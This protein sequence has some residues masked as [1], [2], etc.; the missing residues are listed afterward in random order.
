M[1]WAR[2]AGPTAAADGRGRERVRRRHEHAA[3][4]TLLNQQSSQGA[5]PSHL[6][7]DPTG[8]NVLVA[9]Y[10]SGSVAVLPID[11]DGRLGPVVGACTR[12]QC[13]EQGPAGQAARTRHLPRLHRPVVFAADLGLDQVLVYDF[14]PAKGCCALRRDGPCAWLRA[15]PPGVPS[16]GRFLRH[17]RDG[18]DADR[19]RLRRRGGRSSGSCRPSRPCRPTSAANTTA[20][21]VL[22]RTAASCTARTAATTA[23]LSSRS[24]RRAGSSRPPGTCRRA[25]RNRGTSPSN[26]PAASWSSPTRDRTRSRSCESTPSP[27]G[28]RRAARG[29]RCRGRSACWR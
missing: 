18:F 13:P 10:G 11:A 15:A 1:R 8:R 14:E 2:S 19:L 22:H 27:D 23:S 5:G 25:A 7:V 26:H 16:W 4:L 12:G 28:P 24:T 29:R 3:E 6:V 9:N 17:Q 20:E 21:V